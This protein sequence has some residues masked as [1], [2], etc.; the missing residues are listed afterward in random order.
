[1]AALVLVPGGTKFFVCGRQLTERE[2]VGPE[3]SSDGDCHRGEIE[4]QR[5]HRRANDQDHE[6]Y[7]DQRSRRQFTGGSEPG[8][9]TGGDKEP[10]RLLAARADLQ[11]GIKRE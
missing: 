1:M 10:A 7:G 8:E 3:E 2:T 5:S 9:E 4:Q 6:E 11:G